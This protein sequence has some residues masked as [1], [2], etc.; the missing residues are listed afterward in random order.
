[1]RILVVGKGGRE[2][3]LVTALHESPTPTEIYAYPGSDAIFEL[4]KPVENG[5]WETLGQFMK[6]QEIDLCVSGEESYLVRDAGLAALCE[7]VGVPCWGPPKQTAQLEASKDFAKQFMV[8]NKIPTADYKLTRTISEALDAIHHYPVVLKYNGLAAGKGVVVCNG[9]STAEAFLVKAFSEEQFGDD[10]V[11]VEQCLHGP[12][13]SIFAAVADGQYQIFAPARDYKRLQDGDEGPNTGGMGSVACRAGLITP[14][15][16]EQ[17]EREVVRPTVD[18]LMKEGLPYRGFLYFGLMLTAEGP[19]MLEYNCR[20]GDPEAQAVMPLVTG[21]LAQY[22]YQ[23]AQGTLQPDL[24]DFSDDWSIC[25]VLASK[26]YP[27]DPRKGDEIEGLSGVTTAR[28][29]HAG[30]RKNASGNYETNGGRV[31]AVV[32]RGNTRLEAVEHA[33][34][35]SK[36]VQFDGAQRRSDIGRLN[37]E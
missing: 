31:L 30:T 21:D 5:S 17:I 22:I 7:S 33:Y 16:L 18:G 20:F 32:G 36:K 6:D 34:S 28:V 8:R 10:S 2:H 35:E 27:D 29:Y 26:G 12:E 4:A 9:E 1:M 23:A 19:M 3:A 13:V 25:L 14:E 37:F 11:L 15:L 24:I